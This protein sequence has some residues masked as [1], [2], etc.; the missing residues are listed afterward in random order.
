VPV[1]VSCEVKGA[2]RYVRTVRIDAQ[3]LMHLLGAQ[4]V[5][6]SLLLTGDRRIAQLNREYRHKRGPTDVLSFGQIDPARPQPAKAAKRAPLE[7][8]N[9]LGDVVISIDTAAR[10]AGELDQSVRRRLRT[11]LV[12]GVLHLM[13]FDHERPD[14]ARLMFAVAH[15]FEIRLAQARVKPRHSSDNLLSRARTAK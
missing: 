5:E 12:H 14:D 10:Q 8:N 4:R 6:L 11:L 13:G 9:L 3:T 1:E 2:A 7:I 15:S